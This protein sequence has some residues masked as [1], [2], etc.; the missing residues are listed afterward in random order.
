MSDLRE[1]TD[2]AFKAKQ[3]ND[4]KMLTTGDAFKIDEKP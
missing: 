4:K 3:R 1:F 2:P